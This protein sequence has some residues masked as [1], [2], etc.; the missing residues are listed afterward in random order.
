MRKHAITDCGELG[1][2]VALS[3]SFALAVTAAAHSQEPFTDVDAGMTG[4]FYGSL[5]WGDYDGDGDLDLALAGEADPSVRIN[6]CKV[7]GN[8]GGAFTDIGAGLTGVYVCSLAWGDYDGDGDVDLALAGCVGYPSVISKVYRND[9]GTFVDT[10]A[11]L[12]DVAGGSLAW[13][14]Y[15]NDGDLDL[16][17]AG[18]DDWSG[19]ICSS[20]IYRND[21]GEFVDIGA[22]LTDVCLCSLAWG[23]YDGDGDLDLALAGATTTISPYGPVSKVYRNDAGT[24]SDIG[25]GLVGVRRCSLAWGDY[26]DDGDLDLALAGSDISMV[27]R[28]D[29][30]TFVDIGAGLA[31]V[32]E[33]SV[34]WGDCDNDGDLDLAIAGSGG[35]SKVYRNDGGTFTDIGAGLTDVRASSLAWGDHDDDGDLDLA[36]A[37][38]AGPSNYISKVYRN[39]GGTFNTPPLAP[40]GLSATVAVKEVA[41]HW[42]AAAD[43]ETPQAGLTYNLRVGTTQGGCEI[44]SGMAIVGGSGDGRRLVAAMGNVQHNASWTLHLAPGPYYWSV[45][46]V[47]TAFAGSP[48][49]AEQTADVPPPAVTPFAGGCARG[50]ASTAASALF[51]LAFSLGVAFRRRIQRTSGTR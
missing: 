15:D 3:L 23:D 48:W 9:G 35:G 2:A 10:G 44:M 13:G 49:A 32:Q 11:G 16:A 14:D 40:T 47:D 36:L 33:C 7:Y 29:G 17:L 34:A 20:R 18:A 8:S 37:G 45:Q 28:N 39:N 42:D 27:Y 31:G 22:A 21:G 4:V 41:F 12:T 5:A 24:F 1:R 51:A 50:E 25:A 30:G 26:D 19:G 46:A 43:A 6:I 38:E